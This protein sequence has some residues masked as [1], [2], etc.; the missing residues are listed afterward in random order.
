MTS[1]SQVEENFITDDEP[2]YLRF[3]QLAISKSSS[4]LYAT[5]SETRE[6]YSIDLEDLRN[7]DVMPE[8]EVRKLAFILYPE[9]RLEKFKF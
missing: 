6:L 4:T 1:T 9:E 8:P 7:M 2:K 5:S 3:N